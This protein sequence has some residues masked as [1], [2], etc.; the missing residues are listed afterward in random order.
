VLEE[1]TA[2][3]IH[4]TLIYCLNNPDILQTY[5]NN[6]IERLR[7]FSLQKL[8]ESLLTVAD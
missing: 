6:T 3:K 7:Q 8:S 5:S 1:V 4:K 2:E